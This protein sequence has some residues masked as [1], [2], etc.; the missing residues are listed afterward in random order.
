MKTLLEMLPREEASDTLVFLGDLIDRGP[1]APGCVA[2]VIKLVN[3]NPERVTVYAAITRRCCWTS[4]R[5]KQIFGL[6]RSQV[7]NELL[8]SMQAIH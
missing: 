2:H 1:D 3:A 6:L 8:N 7:A 5:E 4:S